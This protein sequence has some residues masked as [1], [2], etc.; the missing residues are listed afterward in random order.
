MPF[1]TITSPTDPVNAGDVAEFDVTVT[2]LNAAQ[3]VVVVH[4]TVP[5]FT[6]YNGAPAGTDASY[7]FSYVAPGISETAKLLFTVDG[8]NTPP[9]SGSTIT[10]DVIDLARAGSVSKTIEVTPVSTPT[11]TPTPTPKPTP[12]PSPTPPARHF[13]NISTRL[14]V[15]TGD[16]VLIGGFIVTGTQ[17]KTVLV[18]GIGP[19]LPLTG[20]L[21][22]PFL[23]LHDSAGATI[24]SNNDWMNSPDKQAIID[25][26]LAPLNDKEAAILMTLSP[27]SYT[28]ILSGLNATTGVAL[29]EVYDLDPAVDSKLANISTRGLVQTLDNVMIGGLIILSDNPNKIILRAIGPSLPL[30]GALVDPTLELHNSDGDVIFSNDNWRS[31]QEAGIIATG[32]QP[33][34]DKESAIVATLDPGA[35][36]AIVRGLNET[37]GVALIEVYDLQ[38]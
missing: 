1:Q 36:T 13:G 4:F 8:G 14:S 16:N 11:P 5:Q 2:N 10:L 24:A 9:P 29:V 28:A 19:S 12:T 6:T 23:E 38:E 17:S 25:S 33:T 27:G 20:L 35:Y 26:G 30:S 18:R 32:L 31:D 3:Q 22:D 21:A 15:G 37:T 34:K 7:N